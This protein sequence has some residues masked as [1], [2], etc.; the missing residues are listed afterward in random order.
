M[1]FAV[2]LDEKEEPSGTFYRLLQGL[3][4]D[5]SS[6]IEVQKQANIPARN[7]AVFCHAYCHNVEEHHLH[8]TGSLRL[9]ALRLGSLLL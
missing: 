6:F 1:A 4:A 2:Q 5:R 7:V 8:L 9:L 3:P